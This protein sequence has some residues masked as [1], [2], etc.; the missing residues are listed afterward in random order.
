MQLLWF[1]LCSTG[2]EQNSYFPLS[3]DPQDLNALT[4]AHILIG[5][6]LVTL[7]KPEDLTETNQWRLK[8]GELIQQ[9]WNQHWWKRWHSEYLNTLA[10]TPYG[11]FKRPIAKL[12]IFLTHL[13]ELDSIKRIHFE[14]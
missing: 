14:N 1:S 4:P 12:A 5:E 8:R 13:F 10:R 9:M 7:A 2:L 6:P 3:D 11:E